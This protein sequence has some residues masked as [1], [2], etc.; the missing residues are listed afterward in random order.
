MMAMM[1]PTI[2]A[3]LP[4]ITAPWLTENVA[5]FEDSPS[6]GWRSVLE[7]SDCDKVFGMGGGCSEADLGNRNLS[8][9][10]RKRFKLRNRIDE[11]IQRVVKIDVHLVVYV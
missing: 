3:M 9:S 2:P 7:G 10:F 1:I 4:P 6:D 8:I 5:S 11:R